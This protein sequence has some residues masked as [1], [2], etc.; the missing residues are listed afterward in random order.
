MLGDSQAL[1]YAVRDLATLN[2][3]VS[4]TPRRGSVVQA[5]GS[6]GVFALAL[7]SEFA[8]VYCYEPHPA[9]FRMLVANV[10]NSNVFMTQ[11]ALGFDR[12]RV[13][14]S[15]TRR[16]KTH[17][18]PHD[19]VTHVNG[20]GLIP[21]CRVDD[22]GLDDLDLLVLDTEGQEFY[23]LR[24]AQETIERCRPTVMI[25][26]NDNCKFYGLV[27]EDVRTW[28]RVWGYELE[29]RAHSDEVWTCR[30]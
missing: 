22:L 29:F 12:V 5:G 11:A 16:T 2:K 3:A 1:K 23:A 18:P 4:L 10:P 19:G 25:E 14:T 7:A 24:G 9:T 6:L 8:A 20:A 26:I 30:R 17:L 27:P 28:L 21:T 13:S 15:R